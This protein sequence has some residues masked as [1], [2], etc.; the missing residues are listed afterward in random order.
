M[1]KMSTARQISADQLY[2][3][4]FTSVL[5]LIWLL[6]ASLYTSNN[7]QLVYTAVCYIAASVQTIL[8]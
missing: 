8:I 3:F 7:S 1:D 4:A 2:Q 6:S 5:H